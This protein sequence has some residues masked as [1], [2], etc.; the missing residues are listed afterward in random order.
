MAS[1]KAMSVSYEVYS[2][3][4]GADSKLFFFG[5]SDFCVG[6]SG[7]YLGE[8]WRLGLVAADLRVTRAA[9]SALLQPYTSRQVQIQD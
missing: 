8:L 9:D 3:H 7:G 5:G 6:G 1:V 4:T 2:D